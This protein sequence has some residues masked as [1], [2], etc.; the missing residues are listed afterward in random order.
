MIKRSFITLLSLLC[1]WQLIVWITHSPTYILPGPMM[2]LKAFFTTLPVIARESVPT[3]IETI[4]GFI[5]GSLFGATA[6]I[7]LVYFKPAR[8]WFMPVLLISQ[9]LPTFAIAPLFVLWFGYGMASKIAVTMLMIFFPVTSS[10]YDGLK[11]TPQAYLNMA[12]M[13]N[14]SHW[15]TLI[16]IQIPAA[17]PNLA[18]GL[19]VAA[20]FAPMGAVIGEWVGASQGLGYLLLNDN[21]RMQIADMFAVLL[22]IIVLT[23]LLYALVDRLLKKLIFWKA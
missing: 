6:A 18:S 2:S 3:I 21:A 16:H 22:V 11:R 10:F 14:A 12:Q 15:R 19:R 8:L 23:L 4:L 17:L 7:I 5:F 20:T 9:A 1:L 13:M